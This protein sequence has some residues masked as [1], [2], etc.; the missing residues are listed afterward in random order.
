MTDE[1]DLTGRSEP[2]TLDTDR[3]L[4]E[5]ATGYQLDGRAEGQTFAI[6]AGVRNPRC[7][8]KLAPAGGAPFSGRPILA[9]ARSGIILTAPATTT[10]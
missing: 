4:F 8:N 9:A 1:L 5:L 7:D 3:A 10:S 6:C 2:C